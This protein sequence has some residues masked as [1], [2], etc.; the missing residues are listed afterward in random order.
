MFPIASSPKE[1]L[2][3]L[4]KYQ[5]AFIER[6]DI[7][8]AGAQT[9]Q[10]SIRAFANQT[11]SPLDEKT[12]FPSKIAS[13]PGTER[14]V[15]QQYVNRSAC[16]SDKELQLSIDEAIDL[17]EDCV[18]DILYHANDKYNWSAEIYN[19]LL[20]RKEWTLNIACYPFVQDKSN[21]I[22]FPA[23][24]DWG[25]LAIYPYIHGAGLEVYIGGAWQGVMIPPG[26][27]FCYAG[28]IFTR[29]TDGKVPALL[30]RVVQPNELAGSRTSIIFYADPI[31]DMV[32]PDGKVMGDII[33]S[34]LK[35]IGQIK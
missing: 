35:K 20:D 7:F 29:V 2:K 27:V 12:M 34:K 24:K 26:T 31:R 8:D 25:L 30:H 6:P 13:L 33:D 18:N 11:L 16:C 9:Y 21:E 15:I 10:D 32:L 4:E 3:A 17:T 1:V 14:Q 22:L 28:D 5:G 23:H 19:N